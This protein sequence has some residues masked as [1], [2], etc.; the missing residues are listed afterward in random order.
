MCVWTLVAE[1]GDDARHHAMSREHWRIARQRGELG[2][3]QDP[4]RIAERGFRAEDAAALQAMRAKA[5]VGDAAEVSG[6]LR[7]LATELELDELVIN[8]WSFRPDVRRRSYA[9]LAR[10]FGL[11]ARG[12]DA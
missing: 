4:D 9:L 8:S 5:F 2:P 10:E 11:E 1:R 12:A 3:L 6:R 7:A